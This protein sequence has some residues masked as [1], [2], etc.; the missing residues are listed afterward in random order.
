[1]D[2]APK[3]LYGSFT[4]LLFVTRISYGWLNNENEGIILDLSHE[5]ITYGN[6]RFIMDIS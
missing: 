4:V 2:H 5:Q 3:A 6:V 1:M